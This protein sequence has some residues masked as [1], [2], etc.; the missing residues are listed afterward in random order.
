M[1][2]LNIKFCKY[3]L[4][5]GKKSTNI[6]II[7]ELGRYPLYFSLIQSILSYWHRLELCEESSLLHNAYKET[8]NLSKSNVNSWYK[9]VVYF[10]KKINI[11]LS[12]CKK[13]K[14]TYF[15]QQ[16]KKHL[17]KHFLNYW[18]IKREEG[19]NSGK[20]DTYFLYKENF[21]MESYISIQSH[22]IRKT[23]CRFRK[24]AHDLRV[25]RGRYEFVK[26][27]TGQRIPLERNKRTCLLCNQNLV[28]DECH[29]VTDC[30]LYKEERNS[31]FHYVS[32]L[33]KNFILLTKKDKFIWLMSNEDKT[34]LIKFSE[35]LIN[36]FKKRQNTL[37]SK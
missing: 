21:T 4:S 15:K 18:T 32:I 2:N 17:R 25:E 11:S 37:R 5:A 19:L 31:F 28:E 33:N 3:I 22:E 24:S 7:S 26:N 14:T 10:S 35:F 9:S 1:E 13:Y 16:V 30:P 36:A 12:I 29:F 34:I 27:Y 8:I 6:A 23:L 20:L